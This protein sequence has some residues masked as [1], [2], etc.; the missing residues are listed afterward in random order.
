MNKIT[1]QVRKNI[2]TF[3]KALETYFE[4]FGKLPDLAKQEERAE[5][6]SIYTDLK[7]VQTNV[8]ERNKQKQVQKLKARIAEIDTLWERKGVTDATATEEWTEYENCLGLLFEYTHG[9]R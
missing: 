8:E 9:L 4:F 1:P 3:S 7:Y 2:D 5:V 6:F